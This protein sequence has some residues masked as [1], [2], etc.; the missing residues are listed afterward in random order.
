[1]AERL[2]KAV[3]GADVAARENPALWAGT[4]CGDRP[5]LCPDVVELT[6][7]SRVQKALALRPF[8]PRGHLQ[9]LAACA[10]DGDGEQGQLANAV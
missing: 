8:G 6:N 9:M 2:A 5:R 1:M 4:P 3:G 7:A 10:D